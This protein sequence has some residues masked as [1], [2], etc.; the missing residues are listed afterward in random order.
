MEWNLA[1]ITTA[2]GCLIVNSRGDSVT[3]F[4]FFLSF[5]F[6]SFHSLRSFPSPRLVVVVCETCDNNNNTITKTF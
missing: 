3:P 5:F 6:F 4:A 1:A 2:L